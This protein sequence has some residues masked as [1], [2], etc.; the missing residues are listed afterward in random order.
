MSHSAVFFMHR[1]NPDR[2][3]LVPGSWYMPAACSYGSIY[4]SIQLV[5]HVTIMAPTPRPITM[6]MIVCRR[7]PYA[8]QAQQCVVRGGCPV[9]PVC[10]VPS[11][12]WRG[13]VF[14]TLVRHWYSHAI[15]RSHLIRAFI[16]SFLLDAGAELDGEGGSATPTRRCVVKKKKTSG[17]LS[18]GRTHD[19]DHAFRAFSLWLLI[20]TR[21]SSLFPVLSQS[22][23]MIRTSAAVLLIIVLQTEY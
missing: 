13:C 2:N 9:C 5:F 1:I 14:V 3:T 6:M 19:V 8:G 22:S 20:V 4:I 21:R 17:L 11:S 23:V 10:A 18:R 12:V 7:R 15:L 16:H